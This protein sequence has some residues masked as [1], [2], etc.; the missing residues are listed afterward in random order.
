MSHEYNV[1]VSATKMDIKIKGLLA[2][3]T[4][5][6]KIAT[7]LDSQVKFSA[8]KMD[9]K[10]K[11]LLPNWTVNGFFATNL[12]SQDIISGILGDYTLTRCIRNGRASSNAY[13]A[14]DMVE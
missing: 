4:V 8:T 7:N 2:I 11:V 10:T 5:N 13:L 9:S 12:D 6:R 1:M 14:M 3:W